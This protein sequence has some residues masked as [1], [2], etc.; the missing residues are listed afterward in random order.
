MSATGSDLYAS[1]NS[2]LRRGNLIESKEI[3]VPRFLNWASLF[4]ESFVL[5]WLTKQEII[6]LSISARTCQEL[7]AAR[8]AGV[9]PRQG[10]SSAQRGLFKPSHLLLIILEPGRSWLQLLRLCSSKQLANRRGQ[11]ST[12]SQKQH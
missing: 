6:R 2:L 5:N 3:R 7:E 8:S 1:T 12:V 9:C 10:C 4:I 11:V